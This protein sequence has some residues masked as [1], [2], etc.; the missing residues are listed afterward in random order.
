MS[1]AT[2]VLAF[3]KRNRYSTVQFAKD[4]E[5]GRSACSVDRMQQFEID[6][7]FVKAV[8]LLKRESTFSSDPCVS[9]CHL[10]YRPVI[11]PTKKRVV[12]VTYSRSR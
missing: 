11:L 12:T 6:Y 7:R 3:V 1:L 4:N 5:E 9:S 2:Q 10:Q 8:R